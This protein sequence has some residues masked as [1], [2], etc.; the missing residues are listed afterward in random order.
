MVL[1]ERAVAA[2]LE[3]GAIVAAVAAV[4]GVVITAEINSMSSLRIMA[5][6]PRRLVTKLSTRSRSVGGRQMSSDEVRVRRFWNRSH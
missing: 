1:V 5:I 3:E 2:T 6:V 4:V